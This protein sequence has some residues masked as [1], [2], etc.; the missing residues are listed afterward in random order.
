MEVSNHEIFKLMLDKTIKQFLHIRHTKLSKPHIEKV[1]TKHIIVLMS[2]T[3]EWAC[4]ML[5]H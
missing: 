2:L 1:K 3:I 5:A 4:R